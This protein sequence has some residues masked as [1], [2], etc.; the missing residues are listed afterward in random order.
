MGDTNQSGDKIRAKITFYVLLTHISFFMVLAIGSAFN[1]KSKNLKP[2]RV[3]AI[4]QPLEAPHSIQHAVHALPPKEAPKVEIVPFQESPPTPK[5][6]MA[7][8]K[9]IEPKK[10]SKTKALPIKKAVK[11]AKQNGESAKLL[12]EIEK[13]LA[14][15]DQVSATKKQIKSPTPLPN[16]PLFKPSLSS[17]PVA[18]KSASEPIREAACSPDM[19][20]KLIASLQDSLNLP[21]YGVVKIEITLDR[22]GKVVDMKVLESESEK[23]GAYLLERLRGFSFTSLE[24]LKMNDEQRIFIVSFCNE[25]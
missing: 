7:A 18:D 17:K 25:L 4:K 14:K 20:A 24:L 11:P 16:P 6:V 10:A 15:I 19:I 12:K 5:K 3:V 13:S 22:M 2:I 21:E 9:K 23:N 1:P 8:P